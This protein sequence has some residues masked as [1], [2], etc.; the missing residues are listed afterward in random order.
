MRELSKMTGVPP[1]TIRY[2]INEGL[3]PKPL[4]THRNMAYYEESYVARTRLIRELQEKRFLPLT[5]IKQ[6]LEQSESSMDSEEIKTILELEGKLFK[7]ISTLPKFE[8]PDIDELSARTGVHTDDIEELESIGLLWRQPDGLFDEDCV[9]II[10]ILNK[11][12]DAGYTEEAGF[13]SEFLKMYKDLIE[14]LAKQEVKAFSKSVTGRLSFDE[15]AT[16]AENGINLL[17]NLI[18]I[19]RKRM[20]LKISRELDQERV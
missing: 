9:K 17:N 12:R 6:I 2:Y 4:K 13:T 16:M 20:I 14:V 8:P 15:M 10:E 11:L 1:G 19:L 7:N 18:G 3:L 5:I